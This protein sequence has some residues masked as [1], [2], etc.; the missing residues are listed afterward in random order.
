[1]FHIKEFCLIEHLRELQEIGLA[2]FR[3]DLRP[4]KDL[5]WLKHLV[6]LSQHF[7]LEVAKKLKQDYPVDTTKGY[8]NVNKSDVLFKKLKNHRIQR[9]DENYLGEV[10]EV[11]KGEYL[12]VELT[13]NA[14][15]RLGDHLELKGPEGKDVSMQVFSLR[16][17]ALNDIATTDG[18]KIIL[19]NYAGK[20]L[21]RSQV[22]RQTEKGL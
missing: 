1:M 8:F 10:I 14:S 2:F 3:V 18:Q 6:A 4:H 9:K 20:V 16:D 13:K 11:V 22:Y 15:I 12:A 5:G 19:I 17:I 7:D 21:V